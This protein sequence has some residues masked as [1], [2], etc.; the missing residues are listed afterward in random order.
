MGWSGHLG[1]WATGQDSDNGRGVWGTL[2]DERNKELILIPC[3]TVFLTVF[4]RLLVVPKLMVFMQMFLMQTP[5]ASL[6]SVSDRLAH[7]AIFFLHLHSAH[8][9]PGVLS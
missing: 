4:E 1:Q 5:P 7:L 9:T 6:T 2:A 8:Q 3:F